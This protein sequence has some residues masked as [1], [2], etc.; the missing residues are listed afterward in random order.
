LNNQQTYILSID[1]NEVYNTYAGTA[2]ESTILG[3]RSSIAGH[4]LK[5]TDTQ[6]IF[7]LLDNNVIVIPTNWVLFLAPTLVV[8]TPEPVEDN[9]IIE[10]KEND[11]E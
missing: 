3:T 8:E 9:E 4:I 7:E 11:E 10:E 2:T 5:A 1:Y 6:I